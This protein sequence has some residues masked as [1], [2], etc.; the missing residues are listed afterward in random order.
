VP[1]RPIPLSAT[2]AKW[3]VWLLVDGRAVHM[4]Q[5]SGHIVSIV[6]SLIQSLSKNCG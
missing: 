1:L 2:T 4:A 3:Y 6:Q 5:A